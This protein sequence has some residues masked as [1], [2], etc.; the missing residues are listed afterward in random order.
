MPDQLAH[1]LFARRVFEAA[2]PALRAR[3]C[4]DSPA[5]RAGTFGPDPLFND[6]SPRRRAEGFEI[7]RRSGRA[8]MERMRVPVT[9]GMPWA[10]DYAAG[11]F[12]HYAL[13][14]I[15]HP[16]LKAM[17]ARG[18]ARHVAV[19]TAYDRRLY[20]EGAVDVPRRMKLSDSALRAAA[21]MY[22]RVDARRYKRD[23]NAYWQ[24]RRFLL[25]RGGTALARFVGRARPA[26][27]GVIP[28]A[29]PSEG[30]ARG[31]EFLDA[32]IADSALPVA[33][34]LENYFD[35]LDAGEALD[36]WLDV[37]FAGKAHDR[38]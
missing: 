31:M 7:H 17:A 37:D 18:E 38:P 2:K 22:E 11:F 21:A 10:A 1:M 29:Q 36:A 25:A 23:L 19:E 34:Q 4:V 26:W 12:C 20:L 9:Q 24:M 30:V 28:Y 13:D 16:E 33:R 35:A 27:D 14:R 15:C 32:C 8:A 5:F 3:I 6:P